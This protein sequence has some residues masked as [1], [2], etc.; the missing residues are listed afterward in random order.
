MS[1]RT[2]GPVGDLFPAEIEASL[3][4][5]LIGGGCM[6]QYLHGVT[7]NG[8]P[9]LRGESSWVNFEISWTGASPVILKRTHSDLLYAGVRKGTWP[10][11][12]LPM[13]WQP[14]P[15]VTLT[16]RGFVLEPRSR[17]IVRID[18]SD[19]AAMAPAGDY[20][21]CFAPA[22][23]P[24][25]RVRWASQP[26]SDGC[27]RFWLRDLTN[28]RLRLESLRRQSIELLSAGRCDEPPGSP[29]RCSPP[30]R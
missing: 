9:V 26:E 4:K 2:C 30:I 27:H 24:R 11:G 23:V 1:N 13:S 5:D 29:M 28:T 12:A 6:T 22:L 3:P 14:T 10:G 16:S 17:M 7:L 21:I 8:C 18:L 20:E 15:G 25:G 19:L